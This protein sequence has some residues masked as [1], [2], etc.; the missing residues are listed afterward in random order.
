MECGKKSNERS[1]EVLSE[2]ERKRPREEINSGISRAVWSLAT[3]VWCA[4]ACVV[5]PYNS[6]TENK[7]EDIDLEN[8]R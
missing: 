4:C 5:R 3:V 1:R 6:K 7:K 2:N 8:H